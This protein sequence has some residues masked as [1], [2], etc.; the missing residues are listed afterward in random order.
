MK[1]ENDRVNTVTISKHGINPDVARQRLHHQGICQR[2]NSP[3]LLK[4]YRMLEKFITEIIQKT[5][6]EGK[7]TEIR[8]E[9]SFDY[10]H[11]YIYIIGQG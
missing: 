9:N 4:F 8:E 5:H 7:K 3:Y 6:T 10:I 1:T 2:P 11:V